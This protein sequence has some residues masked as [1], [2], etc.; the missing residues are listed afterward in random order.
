[1][2]QLNKGFPIL[3]GAKVEAGYRRAQLKHYANNPL[4]EALQPIMRQDKVIKRLSN[5]IPYR[6]SDKGKSEELRAQCIFQVTRF[7]E[8]MDEHLQIE[9]AMSILIRDGYVDR[10][11]LTVN[12]VR[13]LREGAD[14]VRKAMNSQNIKIPI[15]YKTSGS[16]LTIIGVSGM[17]K[18]T[19]VNNILLKLYPAQVIVHGQYKGRNLNFTQIVWLKLECPPGGSTKGL[20]LNFLQALDRILGNTNYYQTHIKDGSTADQLIPVMAQLAATY[21]IGVL[22][23]DEIQHLLEANTGGQDQML[24]FFVTLKNMIGIPIVLIGTYKA[25]DLLSKEFRQIRRTAEHFGV[26]DWKRMN[27][28][29]AEA[30]IDLK[31][32]LFLKPLWRYQ[33][34]RETVPYSEE[35]SK[36]IYDYSQGITDVAV[37]LFMISQWKAIAEGIEKITPEIIVSAA[38]NEL[39]AFKPVMEAI[40][41][42]N[43]SKFEEYLDLFQKE[44]D[45]ETLLNDVVVDIR[46]KEGLSK[47]AI[48][49]KKQTNDEKNLEVAKW[50]TEAGAS[51]DQAESIV[52]ALLEKSPD[53]PLPVLKS[54]A[55]EAFI[56]MVKRIERKLRTQ[57]KKTE[58][59]LEKPSDEI[60][61]RE[62][63]I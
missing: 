17:G 14:N 51:L 43:D 62:D 54:K 32:E 15:S 22:I 59:K 29:D 56:S 9:Q 18:T 60:D 20:C 24:N 53:L 58:P 52:K 39:K 8:P 34:T 57:A 28:K 21:R 25:W 48:E 33:W 63:V 5:L 16:G 11:P 50:L 38:K 13:I 7:I 30:D 12:G 10:N 61:L 23:I 19:A 45:L 55:F 40:R 1:M 46:R 4:I 3:V 26:V 27:F 41:L 31:W 37:K 2:S 42:K 35:F 6:E 44:L 49:S 47:A 36:L